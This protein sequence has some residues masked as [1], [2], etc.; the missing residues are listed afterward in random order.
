MNV[1]EHPFFIFNLI[2]EALMKLLLL[3]TGISFS[4]FAPAFAGSS[5]T[6]NNTQAPNQVTAAEDADADDNDDSIVF[7]AA[8]DTTM[9]PAPGSSNGSTPDADPSKPNQQAAPAKS[10]GYMLLAGTS[11]SPADQNEQKKPGAPAKAGQKKADPEQQPQQPQL[12]A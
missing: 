8:N 10:N 6:T 2:K 9:T 7:F 4:F 12:I 11:P 1:H 5:A 3:I